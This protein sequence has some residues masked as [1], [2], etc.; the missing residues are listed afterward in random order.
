MVLS[1]SDAVDEP[2]FE[3]IE[4]LFSA[5]DANGWPRAKTSAIAQQLLSA[6]FKRTL[7]H[8]PSAH[9]FLPF[10]CFLFRSRPRTGREQ[11]RV[12]REARAAT[13]W[14]FELPLVDVG[15]DVPA[16]VRRGSRVLPSAALRRL[17]VRPRPALE[18]GHLRSGLRP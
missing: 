15:T 8:L 10:A 12:V 16:V 18:A 6:P 1:K 7:S 9:S 11:E 14:R 13:E 3:R 5:S 4:V 2:L 17:P